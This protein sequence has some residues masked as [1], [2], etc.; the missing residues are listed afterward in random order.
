MD[1]RSWPVILSGPRITAGWPNFAS[2][3]NLKVDD[4]CVFE[5]ITKIQS[6]AFRVSIIPSAGKPSTPILH[7]NPL[8]HFIYIENP[9]QEI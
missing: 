9:T 2:E 6:L 5:L 1:G 3:N 8:F 4:V 7:G